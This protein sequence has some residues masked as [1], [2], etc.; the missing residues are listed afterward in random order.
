MTCHLCCSISCG[1]RYRD[2]S[3]SA[4]AGLAR[5]SQF[6]SQDLPPNGPNPWK[7]LQAFPREGCPVIRIGSTP[8]LPT[9]IIMHAKIAR[10]KLSR[11]FPVG[12]GIP[13]LEIKILLESNPLKSRVFVRRLARRGSFPLAGRNH[14]TPTMGGQG[15]RRKSSAV[16]P[17]HVERTP[18]I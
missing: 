12:Q 8:D 13:P 17:L 14:A 15:G 3:R 10:L 9:K 11:R 18:A 6:A 7:V 2:A 4:D 16:Q 1:C 5:Y